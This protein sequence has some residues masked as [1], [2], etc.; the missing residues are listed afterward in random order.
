MKKYLGLFIVLALT[1]FL[2]VKAVQAENNNSG[3]GSL[4]NDLR[5]ES[6]DH[7]ND[8]DGQDDDVDKDDDNDGSV[9]A[10]DRDDD[11]DGIFDVRDLRP[12]DS[13]NDGRNV[14]KEAKREEIKK[15]IE[16]IREE[17]K[18]KME[19]LRE[20]IK[21]EKDVEKAKIKE[22]RINGRENALQRFDA[23]V[24][25]IS[26][27]KDRVNT[28]ITKLEAKGINVTNAK[29]FVATAETKLT[30]AKNKI[31]EINALLALSINE[32]TPENKTKLRTLAQETQTLIVEAHGALGDAIKS[33]K[34]EIKAM[35]EDLKN[36]TR[37]EGVDGD[38][39]NN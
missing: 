12:S 1:V 20:S 18:T 15:Q 13:D 10:E 7:D 11:N 35:L 27:L 9:D 14:E 2:G 4:N 39:K 32:L 17:A 36:A 16:T 34:E 28:Q 8:N 19:A 31:A 30:N 24:I 6:S 37:T 33:L 3:S 29:V 5:V 22:L 38:N 26:D 23:A 25:R 21:N